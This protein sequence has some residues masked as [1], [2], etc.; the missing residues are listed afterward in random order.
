MPLELHQNNIVNM[1]CDALVTAANKELAGGGGV[2]GVIHRAAG[3]QLL[4]AI[5]KIGGTPTGTAVITPAFHLSAQGIQ[6]I[7]HAVGPIWRGGHQNEAELLA[8]AYQSSLELALQN[9]CQSIAFPAISTGV[10]GYPI[11]QAAITTLQ[12]IQAFL[13][14]HPDLQIKIVLF[15]KRALNVFQRA[16]R[17]P[18][19]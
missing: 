13:E 14:I 7:I 17:K 10:Y 2:D 19:T 12:T 6:N 4:Q 8:S 5:R 16:L 3:P 1:R 11:D 18:Q 9:N 15:E